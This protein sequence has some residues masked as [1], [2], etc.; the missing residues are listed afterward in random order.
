MAKI[1]YS[2]TIKRSSRLWNLP[3]S[4]MHRSRMYCQNTTFIS[5]RPRKYSFFRSCL[6][7]GFWLR[8]AHVGRPS[9]RSLKIFWEKWSSSL[10][11]PSKVVK[12][13]VSSLMCSLKGSLHPSKILFSQSTSF[14]IT[15]FKPFLLS[16]LLFSIIWWTLKI[17]FLFIERKMIFFMTKK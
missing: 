10:I 12:S 3:M 9:E 1:S 16:V 15:I 8:Y 6:C 13:S 17:Y 5:D 7:W 11:F 14:D 4:C 2:T